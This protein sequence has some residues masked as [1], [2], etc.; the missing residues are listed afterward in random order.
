MILPKCFSL[1]AASDSYCLRIYELLVKV[2]M[3][4]F[5]YKTLTQIYNHPIFVAKELNIYSDKGLRVT[6]GHG[7]WVL[8]LSQC[9]KASGSL[10]LFVYTGLDDLPE[11]LVTLITETVSHVIRVSSGPSDVCIFISTVGP[12][13]RGAFRCPTPPIPTHL[14]QPMQ[15]Q[16]V[17]ILKC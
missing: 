4:S 11:N 3:Y 1:N 6:L 17:V 9:M 2:F 15:W 5:K 12:H 10:R 7:S 14:G 8:G 16:S 13:K